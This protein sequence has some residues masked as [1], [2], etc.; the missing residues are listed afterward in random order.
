ME[1]GSI[2]GFCYNVVIMKAFKDRQDW[3]I[4]ISAEDI[5]T[6]L[7]KQHEKFGCAS[8]DVFQLTWDTIRRRYPKRHFRDVLCIDEFIEIEMHNRRDWLQW[9]EKN[10][11]FSNPVH[12]GYKFQ[13]QH[14][15][16]DLP[17]ILGLLKI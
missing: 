9:L 15:C 11:Y 2:S 3:Y 13:L 6:E 12:Q 5:M 17:D 8:R 1:V 14:S 4:Q 16:A 7:I 10:F